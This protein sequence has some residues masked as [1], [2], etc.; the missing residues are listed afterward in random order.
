MT[1]RER[2]VHFVG[3][4]APDDL[5]AKFLD[6]AFRLDVRLLAAEHTDD[7]GDYVPPATHRPMEAAWEYVQYRKYGVPRPIWFPRVV[8]PELM[9]IL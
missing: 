4:F 1:P 5:R 7:L 9:P 6:E 8:S 3:V 2:F